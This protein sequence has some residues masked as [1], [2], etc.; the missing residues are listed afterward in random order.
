MLRSESRLGVDIGRVLIDDASHPSGD[1]TSFIRGTEDDVLETP[2]M[3]GAF[4]ALTEL[5][6]VLDGRVWLVSKCRARVQARTERWLEH[7]RFF[8]ITG[9][10]PSHVRF[11]I[12]RADKA[13]ICAELGI[14]HF[15]D[16]RVDVLGYLVGVVAHL[17]LFASEGQPVPEF[18]IATP[19]WHEAKQRILASL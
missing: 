18:A 1:D 10:D 17:F 11:C 8:P 14:T 12:E 15:V 2:Q 13:P 4:D 7:H 5:C 3:A 9:I 16:D 19:N 6:S